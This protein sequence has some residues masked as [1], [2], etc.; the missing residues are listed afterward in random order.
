MISDKATK[1]PKCGCPT[2]KGTESH[3][4]QEKPQVQPVY[5]EEE[6]G[7]R[8][9]K[10]LYGIIVLLV[11]IIAGGCYWWYSQTSDKRV[12]KQL[13]SDNVSEIKMSVDQF[14]KVGTLSAYYA[15]EDIEYFKNLLSLIFPLL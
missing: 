15:K 6:E 10:W 11:V 12:D 14:E 7:G 4:P 8:S 5:Y 13:E 1:C 2:T 9:R 3:I